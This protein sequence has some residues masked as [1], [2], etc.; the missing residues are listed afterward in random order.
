MLILSIGGLGSESLSAEYTQREPE[1]TEL[2]Q[3]FQNYFEEY[4]QLFPTFATLIGDHRY[5]DKLQIEISEEH[6]QK[7]RTLYS[8]YLKKLSEVD[9]SALQDRDRLNYDVLKYDLNLRLEELQF[10]EHLIPDLKPYTLFSA[11]APMEFR[12][13]SAS[14][15]TASYYEKY[16]KRL[17]IVPAWI[18]TAIA[19]M[20]NGMAEGFVSSRSQ[21][22]NAVTLI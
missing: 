18:D 6:R 19:N 8:T 9:R 10:K 4:L 13:A 15:K 22:F 1:H 14:L 2:N 3:L 11:I 7:Q 21:A 12:G 20:R 16:L 17:Q 5:D